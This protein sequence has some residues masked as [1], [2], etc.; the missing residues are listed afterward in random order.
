MSSRAPL[1]CPNLISQRT[2]MRER[3]GR[4]MFCLPSRTPLL[5]RQEIPTSRNHAR[6]VLDLGA[7]RPCSCT[8]GGRYSLPCPRFL[9]RTRSLRLCHMSFEGPWHMHSHS[10]RTVVHRMDTLEWLVDQGKAAQIAR[11]PPDPFWSARP[12]VLPSWRSLHWGCHEIT[13]KEDYSSLN[14]PKGSN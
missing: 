7:H 3:G 11:S 6:S 4:W 5:S 1:G 2:R 8:R 13:H 12:V 10:L 9:T 14:C